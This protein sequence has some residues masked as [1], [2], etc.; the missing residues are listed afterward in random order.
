[1]NSRQRSL[2][3]AFTALVGTSAEFSSPGQLSRSMS[4][5]RTRSWTQ[6]CPTAKCLTRPIPARQQSPIA[7][8]LSAH[9][10]REELKPRS[11]A[12]TT[13]PRL[14]AATLTMPANSAS[15]GLKAM[16]F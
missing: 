8:R 6:S 1:M 11:W 2:N 15:P 14:S 7:A 13:S 10:C 9:T 3:S 12:M 5:D 4:P 16:V